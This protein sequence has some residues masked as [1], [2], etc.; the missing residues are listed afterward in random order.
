MQGRCMDQ[1][2]IEQQL[3]VMKRIVLCALAVA[4]QRSLD[5][6]VKHCRHIV[7]RTGRLITS[8]QATA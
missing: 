1:C 5:P 2:K 3:M 7:Y 4:K 6:E 8:V